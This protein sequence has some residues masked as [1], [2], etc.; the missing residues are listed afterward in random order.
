MTNAD[1]ETLIVDGEDGE[2]ARSYDDNGN[3]E[4]ITDA[5]DRVTRI[6]YDALNRP[7]DVILDDFVDDLITPSTP[8]GVTLARYRY[9]PAR[10]PRLGGP[11]AGPLLPERSVV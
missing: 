4:T 9:D 8:R 11:L 10:Q 7:I 5:E 2:I 6:V 3:V 1:C